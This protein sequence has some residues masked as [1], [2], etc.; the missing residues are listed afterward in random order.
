ME[1]FAH[2]LFNG[3]LYLFTMH[4]TPISLF[5]EWQNKRRGRMFHFFVNLQKITQV[6]PLLLFPPYFK[7]ANY[8]EGGYSV[9]TTVCSH[10]DQ[11]HCD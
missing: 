3:I 2:A 7:K 5:E 8:Y 11:N 6:R 4:V 9:A 1:S 10:I